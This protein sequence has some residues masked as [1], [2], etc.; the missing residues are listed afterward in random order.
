MDVNDLAQVPRIEQNIWQ[1][2]TI[3]VSL[4]RVF[5]HHG[6]LILGA[7]DDNQVVRGIA[8]AFPGR[9]TKGDMY[10]HSHMVGVD[11]QFQGQGIGTQLK[12]V[13]R[14]YAR[15]LGYPYIGWTFDPLQTGNAWFNLEIL[16]A[17]VVRVIENAYGSLNDALNGQTPSHRLW[18]Q[19][20]VNPTVVPPRS[21]HRILGQIPI[22]LNIGVMRQVA[23]QEATDAANQMA[24]AFSEQLKAGRR[25]CRVAREA[26]NWHYLFCQ[27]DHRHKEDGAN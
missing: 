11:P 3:P 17:E 20:P 9:S 4:L 7:L 8:V 1:S 15:D 24:R 27:T 21:D 5:A 2:Y 23:P 14:Q 6:G 25:V 16:R 19:W 10:L 26:H 13:Q 22:P 18:V 12:L